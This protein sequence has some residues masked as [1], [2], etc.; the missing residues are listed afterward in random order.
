MT[1]L[2]PRKLTPLL[3]ALAA[4]YPVLGHAAGVARMDFVAGNVVALG[5]GGVSRPL[6]KGDEVAAGETIST[7]D[8]RAQVRF[9]DGAMVSLQPQTDFRVDAYHYAGKADGS[10][11][12]FFSLLKGGM[13]TITGLI[14]RTNQDNYRVTTQAATIGIRGTEY[15]ITYGNG[16]TITTGEGQVQVCNDGGCLLLSGGESAFVAASGS[17]PVRTEIRA[18][19]PPSQPVVSP[20][21][22]FAAGENRNAAG[23][24]PL[25]VPVPVP[26]PSMVSG[27]GY[28]VFGAGTATNVPLS[29]TYSW[30]TGFTD[31][32]ATFNAKQELVSA[33]S[34]NIPYDLTAG[35]TAAAFTDGTVAWGR[36]SSAT[37]SASTYLLDNFHYVAGQATP[38]VDLTA[39]V[40][41]TATYSLIGY[42]LPT[43]STGLV[44]TQAVTGSMSINFNAS[45]SAINLS[46]NVPIDGQTFTLNGNPSLNGSN[47]GGYVT[48]GGCSGSPSASI[49]G[50][51]AGQNASGAGLVYQFRAGGAIGDVSGAA[52]FKQTGLTP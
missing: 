50:F 51:L 17:Q 14:G 30:N 28:T 3:V 44:G 26:G 29:S 16:I 46:M 13:R 33:T 19:L 9:S 12:G 11:Q 32:T 43:S 6:G 45:V 41:R 4:A 27:P 22:F 10:E 24:V 47:I 34:P 7:R 31:A 52:A 37:A 21:V 40:G 49:H 20:Q 2:T 36:W 42:T 25:P 39:L 38:A 35:Q 15:S 48:C 5:S 18:A 8:G 23:N 1:S